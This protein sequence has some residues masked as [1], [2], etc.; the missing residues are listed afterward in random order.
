MQTSRI[1][2][3]IDMNSFF[4]SCEMADN[5]DLIGKAVVIAHNDPFQRSI[6]VSPSYEA[7]KYGI[8]KVTYFKKRFLPH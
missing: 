5:E 4:A 6:I 2:F 3:H 8:T 1:I 7:R